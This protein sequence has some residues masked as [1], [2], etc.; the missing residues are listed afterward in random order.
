MWI[1]LLSM[2]CFDGPVSH[3]KQTREASISKPEHYRR[4]CDGILLALYATTTR[5]LTV[6]VPPPL[7]DNI[8]LRDYANDLNRG[9]FLRFRDAIGK[10]LDTL[11]HLRSLFSWRKKLTTAV[12]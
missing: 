11:G 4:R 9:N 6:T 2:M 5:S 3:Q 12:R 10:L 7:F 8:E 1:P